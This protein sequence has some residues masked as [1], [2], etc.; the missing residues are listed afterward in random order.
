MANLFYWEMIP[1]FI[2]SIIRI[3][4]PLVFG[5]LA[6]CITQKSG[7]LNMAVDSMML[8]ASLTG[9]VISSYTQNP[10]LGLLAGILAAVLITVILSF[11]TFSWKVDLYLA[12]I[13]LNTGMS[14]ATVFIMYLLTGQ[15]ASTV[16]YLS[17]PVLPNIEIPFIKDIPVL[18][19]ILSGHHVLTYVAVLCTILM[20]Y[21]LRRTVLGMRIRSVGENPDAAVSVGIDPVKIYYLSFAIAGIM[22][23]MGG[24]FMSMGYVSWF[25]RDITAGRGYIG[26]SATNIT[27]ADPVWTALASVFFGTAQAFANKLQLTSYSV[28]LISSIPYAGTILVL[29]VLSTIR[30]IR[31]VVKHRR[32]LKKQEEEIRHE[33]V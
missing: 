30:N 21:L 3:S 5:A 31:A 19:V 32:D 26:M 15:K 9:V 1:S 6:A 13:A 28:D 20:S 22:A 17:S 10:W 25:Q 4:T 8:A 11:A 12:S 23:G 2:A 24:C 29:I 27:G 7:V 33:M 14:G 18:G 16:G